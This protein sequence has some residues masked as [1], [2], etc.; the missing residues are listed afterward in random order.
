M[1]S[2]AALGGC[3]KKPEAP[4]SGKASGTSSTGATHA[5]HDHAPGAKHD[6]HDHAD[7]DKHDDHGAVV[8]LG[9]CTI[10]PFQVRASRDGGITA[11]GE[12]P[13]DLWVTPI[14]GVKVAAV[15]AWIGTQDAKGSIKAKMDPEKDSFHS[16]IEVP[17]P[18]PSGSKLW[19][20]IEDDKGTKAAGSFDLK[21]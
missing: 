7:G 6:E 18:L 9:S 12:A 10:G 5:D 16:H 21:S 1:G 11:G 8:E 4:A 15:R 19:V 17:N 14:A 20:E 3:E 13:V 2:L